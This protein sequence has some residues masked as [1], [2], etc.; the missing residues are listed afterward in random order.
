LRGEMGF[1]FRDLSFENFTG[2]EVPPAA[3]GVRPADK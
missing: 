1:T 3:L 2:M